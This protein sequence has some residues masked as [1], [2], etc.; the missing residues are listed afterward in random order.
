MY[1]Q[2]IEN[3]KICDLSETFKKITNSDLVYKIH[4]DIDALKD[5]A[6]KKILNRRKIAKIEYLKF[7]IKN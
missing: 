4:T 1:L 5:E 7:I 6:T 3:N 2:Y